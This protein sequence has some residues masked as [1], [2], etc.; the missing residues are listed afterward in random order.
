[1]LGVVACVSAPPLGVLAS[2]PL[3]VLPV[4]CGC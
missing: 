2:V 1:M 4:M 3:L